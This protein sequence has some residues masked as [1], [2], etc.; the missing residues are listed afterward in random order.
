MRQYRSPRE[1]AQIKAILRAC[2]LIEMLRRSLYPRDIVSKWIDTVSKAVDD[3][4]ED[5]EVT[6]LESLLNSVEADAKKHDP[7][8]QNDWVSIFNCTLPMVVFKEIS[9]TKG[10]ISIDNLAKLANIV[11]DVLRDLTQIDVENMSGPVIATEFLK[12]PCDS[13]ARTILADLDCVLVEDLLDE[14]KIDFDARRAE[15]QAKVS[16]VLTGVNIPL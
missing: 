10:Q 16:A 14:K 7:I 11:A 12:L 9:A 5:S 15:T 4:G 8:L 1:R 2:R 13:P 6:H 3:M